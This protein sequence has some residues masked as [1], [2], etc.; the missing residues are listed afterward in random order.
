[1]ALFRKKT[2]ADN[3]AETSAEE[4]IGTAEAA[5]PEGQSVSPA[6]PAAAPKPKVKPDMYTWI[7]LIA[8]VCLIVSL[9][10]LILIVNKYKEQGHRPLASQAP[11]IHMIID[12]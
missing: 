8:R 1:M 4:G 10:Y 5:T 2:Q 12:A 6:A 7:L 11:A 3:P 9:V